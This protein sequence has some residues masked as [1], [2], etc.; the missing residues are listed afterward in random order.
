MKKTRMILLSFAFIFAAFV[1]TPTKSEASSIVNWSEWRPVP[2]AGATCEAR[3]GTDAY[4]YYKGATTVD[5]QLQARGKCNRIYYKA[6]IAA[7]GTQTGYFST[8]TPIKSINISSF[9]VGAGSYGL[10]MDAEL[11]ADSAM[12]NF[13][14]WAI[15][16][17]FVYR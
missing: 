3:V 4:T 11:F 1:F 2:K 16:S 17:I 6:S 12:T 7:K 9:T 10:S 5:Y 8:N 15:T 13:A 14:G